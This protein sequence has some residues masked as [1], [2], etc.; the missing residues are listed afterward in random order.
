[1][2]GGVPQQPLAGHGPRVGR[3]HLDRGPAADQY[4]RLHRH[5]PRGPHQRLPALQGL[6]CS[7]RLVSW[8]VGWL[9][10]ALSP[11]NHIGL[12]QDSEV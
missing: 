12:D 1:M 2:V 11:V 7:H 3:H 5:V 8:L 9:V 10:G 6:H 4:Q